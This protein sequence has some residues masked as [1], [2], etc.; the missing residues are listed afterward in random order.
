[1]R[2][3]SALCGRFAGLYRPSAGSIYPRL[4]TLVDAGLVIQ[5]GRDYALTGTGRAEVEARRNELHALERDVRPRQRAHALRAE[6]RAAADEV[7]SQQ[8]R[9]NREKR[10]RTE[11][12]R[13]DLASLQVELRVFS[14]DVMAAARR[15]EPDAAALTRVLGALDE[16]RATVLAALSDR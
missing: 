9:V 11:Q 13:G 8:R 15:A 7:R 12:R 14:A 3:K 4:T 2:I 1:M 6:V 10:T 5:E 16:A